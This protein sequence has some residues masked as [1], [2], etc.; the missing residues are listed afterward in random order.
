MRR[1]GEV[2]KT[3]ST[4]DVVPTTILNGG[5]ETADLSGWEVEYGDA[6]TNDSV[7]S[8]ETFSYDYDSDHKDIEIGKEGNC[9]EITVII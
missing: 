4:G 1:E 7:S 6:F 9:E 8:K 3:A 5:F 2:K